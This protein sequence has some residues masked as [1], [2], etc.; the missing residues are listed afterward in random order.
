MTDALRT[1]CLQ[2]EKKRANYVRKRRPVYR[3]IVKY[4]RT[5]GKQSLK[6]S[7][8]M[9][10]NNTKWN[11]KPFSLSQ[12][13]ERDK[14]LFNFVKGMREK[15]CPFPVLSVPKPRESVTQQTTAA[16]ERMTRMRIEWAPSLTSQKGWHINKKN[17][18]QYMVTNYGGRL[19]ATTKFHHVRWSK[20]TTATTVGRSN[21]SMQN[22]RRPCPETPD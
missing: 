6:K 8:G 14:K 7:K 11:P 21:C 22:N 1:V 17:V 4:R 9:T 16:A 5:V 18:H 19:I 2:E 15:N 13:G 12:R 10:K 20:Q 3:R